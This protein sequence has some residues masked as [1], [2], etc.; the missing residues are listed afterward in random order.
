MTLNEITLHTNNNDYF[1]H[2]QL[3]L[4]NK[5][6]DFAAAIL[7]EDDGKTGTIVV[8][9]NATAKRYACVLTSA[10]YLARQGCQGSAYVGAGTPLYVDCR[11]SSG[12]IWYLV[13]TRGTYA[14][15]WILESDVN[16]GPTRLP[17]CPPPS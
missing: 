7:K 14:W 5:S 13:I 3:R 1:R 9:Q 8:P 4:S 12:G 2:Y 17:I 15:W 16:Y 11:G 10:D 6:Q